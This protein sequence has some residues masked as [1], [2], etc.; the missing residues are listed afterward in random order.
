MR[1]SSAGTITERRSVGATA[2]EVDAGSGDADE[3]VTGGA[4]VVALSVASGVGV[5]SSATGDAGAAV[6]CVD[7]GAV[8]GGAVGAGSAGAGKGFAA[9]A[10]G[11][12]AVVALEGSG[13]ELGALFASAAGFRDFGVGE[14]LRRLDDEA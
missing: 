10:V 7:A 8:A 14:D 9:I 6:L 11:A 12:F 5:T 1:I 3:V 13:E 4:V 2:V